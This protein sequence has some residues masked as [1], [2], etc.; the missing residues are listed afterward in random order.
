MISTLNAYWIRVMKNVHAS[1]KTKT[2][3]AGSM[4]ISI[5]PGTS[6]PLNIYHGQSLLLKEPRNQALG[7][8]NEAG[9]TN[10]TLAQPNALVFLLQSHLFHLPLPLF[11]HLTHHLLNNA[12]PSPYTPQAQPYPA[13]PWDQANRLCGRYA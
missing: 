5:F 10:F 8:S 4:K 6:I 7:F 11:L 3:A 2:D 9:Q 13:Y 12:P 1:F